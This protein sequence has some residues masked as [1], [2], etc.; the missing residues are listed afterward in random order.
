MKIVEAVGWYFP[1]SLGGTEVYVAALAERFRRAGHEVLV[2]APEPGG[3]GERLERHDDTT[4]FRWPTPAE[5][6]RAEVQSRVPV[7]GAK[8]FADWLA[9]ERPDVVHFHTFVPGLGRFEVQAARRVG[10]RVF[11]TTHASSLGYTCL[12]GTLMQWGAEPCDGLVRTGKCAACALTERGVP[13]AAAQLLGMVP[14]PIGAGLAG[15]PGK[16]GTALGMTGLVARNRRLQR[17]LLGAL[18]AFVVLTEGARQIVVANGAPA[19]KVIVNRLGIA[20]PALSIKPSPTEQPTRRPVRVGYLGRFDPVKG[21]HDLARA[22]AATARDTPLRVEF[23]GPA[24]TPAER[25]VLRELK[26]ILHGDSRVHFLPAVSPAEVPAVLA[27]WD[28]LACPSVCAEGGPTVA[29][30]A[31]GVGT[32]VVGSRIGGL[33]EIVEDTVS[34]RLFAPGDWR[35]L[36]R[37][38]VALATSPVTTIDRWRTALPAPRTMDEVARDYLELFDGSQP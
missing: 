22:V 21:V 19:S 33:A 35:D 16:V 5:P 13:R 30:E 15:L 29:L 7:R 31:F 34:G 28:V 20:G 36:S 17:E 9:R 37:L 2:A 26:E 14:A 27:G 18:E 24:E 6:T 25:Q 4:V 23:R 38:L 10:A 32:P 12:R 11:A 3:T 1:T 8:A